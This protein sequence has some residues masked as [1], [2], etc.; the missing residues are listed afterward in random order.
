MTQ[1]ELFKQYKEKIC[2]YCKGDCNKGITIVK[3]YNNSTTYAKCVDYEKDK[4]KIQGYV[5]PLERTAKMGS[6]VMKGFIS[7]WSKY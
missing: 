6:C 2:P 1:E 7:D 3:D 4:D 5:R